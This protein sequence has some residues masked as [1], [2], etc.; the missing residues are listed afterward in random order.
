[1]LR[2]TACPFCGSRETTLESPFGPTL[3][4]AIHYCNACKQSFEQFKPV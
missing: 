4:R 3:C 2:R 1:M